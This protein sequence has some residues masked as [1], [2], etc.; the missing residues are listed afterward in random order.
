MA[1]EESSVVAAASNP[2]NFGPQ[3]V[4]SKQPLSI[5]KKIGQHFMYTGEP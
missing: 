3:E 4:V 2:Q 5:P 1:I